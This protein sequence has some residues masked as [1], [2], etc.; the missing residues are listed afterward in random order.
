MANRMTLLTNRNNI[1]PMLRFITEMMMIFM[2]RLFAKDAQQRIGRR[3]LALSDGIFNETTGFYSIRMT[4]SICFDSFFTFFA[5]CVAFLCSLSF[6][7]L[8]MSSYFLPVK[9]STFFGLQIGFLVGFLISF[10]FWS[11]V[12]FF[13]SLICAYFAI[14]SKSIWSSTVLIELRSDL[15]ANSASFGYDCLRHN[16]LL[17]RRLCLEPNAGPIPVSG[18]L[19]YTLPRKLRQIKKG[20]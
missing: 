15:F 9:F 19:Y 14:C 10:I 13:N 18:S 5:L 1:K 11:F 12:I 8:H 3:Q 4:Q 7:G 16:R 2:C 20:F 6:F 17:D